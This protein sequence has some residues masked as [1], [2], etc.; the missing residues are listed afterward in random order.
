MTNKEIK[1]LLK[2]S[3]LFSLLEDSLLD[4]LIGRFKVESFDMGQVVIKEGDPADA[5]YVIYGGR[6]RVV[7]SSDGHDI[8]LAT[9]R[10]GDFFGETALLKNEQRTATI[11]ASGELVVG[12]LDKTDFIESLEQEP[13]ALTYLEK[14]ISNLAIRN[15]LRQF[16]IFSELTSKEVTAW[17]DQLEFEEFQEGDIVFRQGDQG[18]RFYI[19]TSGKVDVVLE[20]QGQEEVIATLREGEFFG[21]L[22]LLSDRP[23]A[24]TIRALEKLE[25]AWMGKEQFQD[26]VE[27]S[28]KVKEAISNIIGLYNL[29]QAPEDLR[30]GV[31]TKTET[32]SAAKPKRIDRARKDEDGSPEP[33]KRPRSIARG[34]LGMA[35]RKFKYPFI[36]QYDYSDCGAASLGMI[37]KYYG[38]SVSITRLRDLANVNTDGAS[39][40]SVAMA[41][42]KIGFTSRSVKATYENLLRF[43]LP[44]IIHWDGYHY[45]VLY[46]INKRYAILGDPARG[47][48]NIPRDEFLKHFT[49]FALLLEPTRKLEGMEENQ[50]SFRRFFDYALPYKALLFEVLLCSLLLS[51]FGLATPVFTQLIVDNVVV[52]HNVTLLNTVL[53]GM[54]II[55]VLTILSSAL[56]T[57]LMAH[58]SN[59]MEMSM[60]GRFY[61]HILSLPV[62][63]FE[64]R[65]VG[66]ILARFEENN[67]IKELMTGT[68][69]GMFIDVLM[70]F[71]YLTVLFIYSP[72]LAS[73]VVMFLPIFALITI[74]FTPVFKRMSRVSFE[75]EAA[76]NSFMVESITGVKTVKAAS[77]ELA[78]RWE[79]EGLLAKALRTRFQFAMLD[80]SADSAG[81]FFN[82][83]STVV[84]LYAGANMV[85]RGELTI[86]QLIAFIG[87]VGRVISPVNKLVGSWNQIQESLIAME[88]INDVLDAAPEE[89]PDGEAAE[90]LPIS[91]QVK[92]ENVSF[93]YTESDRP[94]LRNLSFE[95][96]PGQMVAIIGR[97]GSGKTTMM[98]LLLRFGSPTEG[99]ILV[100]G[101]DIQNVS[102]SS[103]RK[104]MGIVLQES[105]LFSGT[106]RE[107]IALGAQEKPFTSVVEAATLAAAHDFISEMPSGYQ[108]DVGERGSKLSGGQRQRIAIA[109]ALINNPR[110]LIF[111]EATSALD[112]ES[113]KAIQKGLKQI[114]RDRTSFIIAHRLST[115]QNADLILVVDQGVLVE[116]GTH[117]ELMDKKGLYYYLNSLSLDLN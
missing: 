72:N 4:R 91:G 47:I 73:I 16:T 33:Y 109:R 10:K 18:D 32:A 2:K 115:I 56:R 76:T 39:L 100:D 66:D 23:R 84:L 106:I 57:Y 101:I 79:Y 13:E 70:I 61:R 93:A 3:A 35:S 88:R 36:E 96:Q 30:F 89:D 41:A 77:V 69:I 62:K 38:K 74:C 24:A 75:R 48:L 53:A 94:V 19:I 27:K 114:T 81:G 46:E 71:V 107:N 117:H 108:S 11:R 113:E 86:G 50:S 49:G 45:V 51:F 9:L 65:K 25:L 14:Y 58:I 78:N 111:D 104:Q 8:T 68:T 20:S 103:L 98:N 31:T 92:F 17:L 99:R 21:E 5:F 37:C 112:N 44:A 97:S 102:V 64:M 40:M 26:L 1:D 95:I 82:S 59:K 116:K 105:Y 42:E 6:A 60:L 28:P 90:M 63:F 43:S 7:G 15:F 85:I 55:T 83:L 52:H 110:I 12:R 67:K 22:A 34:L 29:D 87:I 80:L 54:L